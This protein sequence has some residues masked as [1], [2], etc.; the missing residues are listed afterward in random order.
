MEGFLF[1]VLFSPPQAEF[2]V[3]SR[4]YFRF[5]HVS[6]VMFMVCFWKILRLACQTP[7]EFS[8]S[9]IQICWRK[10]GF[11]FSWDLVIHFIKEMVSRMTENSMTSHA[12]GMKKH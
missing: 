8:K 12:T 7:M 11:L 4:L 1:F 9:T 2:F 5:L 10:D 3:I 6:G